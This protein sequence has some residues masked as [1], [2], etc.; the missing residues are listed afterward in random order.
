M[1]YR[2]FTIHFTNNR[3]AR[4]IQVRYED[5]LATALIEL[6]LGWRP[7]FVVVGGAARLDRS[8]TAK[9]YHL[10]HDALAPLAQEW[11]AYVVDGATDS[12]VIQMMGTAREETAATFPLVGVAA[13]GT[14]ALTMP[15]QHDA[16]PLEPN[17]THFILVPGDKWGDESRWIARVA[18]RLAASQPSVT[19]LINGG[20][21]TY[22]DAAHSVEHD[23]P[24]IVV[25]GSGR[26]ADLLAA[27]IR[28]EPSEERAQRL[29]QTGLL[30]AI[31][32]SAGPEELW[33]A[34]ETSVRRPVVL[35]E[36]AYEIAR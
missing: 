14:V 2:A 29:V 31:D 4:A 35:A 32:L 6:G 9:I 19:V 5:E 25:A 8:R 10:F 33:T 34:I 24:V 22:Q 3:T 16:F 17:H 1:N 26:T 13:I 15:S 27:A 7:T 11:D 12:G 30:S 36:P 20:E 23:R 21:V 28:G 18:S